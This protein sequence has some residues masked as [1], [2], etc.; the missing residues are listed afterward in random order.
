M[1]K[2]LGD[3]VYLNKCVLDSVLFFQIECPKWHAKFDDPAEFKLKFKKFIA[4]T[5]SSCAFWYNWTDREKQHAIEFSS[6]QYPE[7]IK[8]YKDAQE[9]VETFKHMDGLVRPSE[10]VDAE[11]EPAPLNREELPKDQRKYI[12]EKWADKD[13][14]MPGDSKVFP[15]AKF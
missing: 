8:P 11:F 9:F 14:L 13:P 15:Y 10:D 3:R 2:A 6:A 7:D 5:K 4:E 12:Y 1:Q